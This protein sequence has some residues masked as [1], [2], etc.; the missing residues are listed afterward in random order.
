MSA[1][2]CAFPCALRRSGAI[3]ENGFPPLW[4]DA[5]RNARDTI[6]M[7]RRGLDF[8]MVLEELVGFLSRRAVR[9]GVAGA[10]ALHAYGLTR[11][12][13]DLDLIVEEGGRDALLAHMASLGYE[14]LH[15]S[16]GF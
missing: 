4:R 1:G 5:L 8:V 16:A 15:A 14:Q 2:P 13:S 12:T 7:G 9:H 11:A 6:S 10:M 3:G